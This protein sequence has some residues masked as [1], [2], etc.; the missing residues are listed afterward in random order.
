MRRREFFTLVGGVLGTWP[1]AARAQQ[2]ERTRRI[3]VLMGPAETDPDGQARAGA[4]RDALAKLGWVDGRSVQI[5]Y[6]W[7]AGDVARA[8]AYASEFVALP[9]DAIVVNGTA[10]LAAAQEATKSIPVVFAQ[11]SDPVGGGFVSSIARPGG[12]ITGCTDFEYAFGVK[13][14]EV[15]REFAPHVARAAVLY[16]PDNP[17]SAKFLPPIEAAAASSGVKLLRT[18]VRD[19]ED[20]TRAIDSLA[21]LPPAGLI[22]LPSVPAITYRD[23]IIAGA[24]RHRLP[25]VYP[26]RSLVQAGGLV[27]YGV[28]VLDMYRVAASYVD[29][30]LKGEKAAD[31]P[32]QFATRFEFVINLKSAKQ[33]GLSVPT[34]TLLHATETIE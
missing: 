9:V 29:R 22:V 11:V 12:N 33:I 32:I 2:S 13:W 16:D 17:N 4:F 5:D 19:A 27:S 1:F 14:L 26:Y 25:A 30:I 34:S 10:Q 8:K 31:L 20:I 15:L 3:G 6:R 18:A 28:D 23:R 7:A 21:A 24:A